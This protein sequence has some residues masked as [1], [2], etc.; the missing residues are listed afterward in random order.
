MFC[1][2]CGSTRNENSNFCESCGADCRKSDGNAANTSKPLTFKQYVERK[3][4]SQ[5]E[6][7]SSIA[8]R[9]KN[10]R[11]A[12]TAKK[13]KKEEFVK[14]QYPGLLPTGALGHGAPPP[15]L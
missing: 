13:G 3:T 7:F 12:A 8:K 14:V 11:F 4:G 1:S 6:S 9:K 2:V 5:D 15:P 10:D